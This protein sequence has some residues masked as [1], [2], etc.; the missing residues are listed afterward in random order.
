MPTEG[1]LQAPTRHP[2]GWQAP[3][4]YD[5]P[6]A[7]TELERIFHICHGCRRC[8]SLCGAFPT[9]FDLVDQGKTG[10][11][12]GVARKDY[13]KVVDQCYLC[14]L[15]YMTKCPYVPPH[16][17][18]V[19]FPHTMLRAKAIKFKQGGVGFGEKFLAATDVHGQFAGIPVVVQL[20]NAVNRARPARALME[21]T[22][23]VD[24]NAWLPAL[25]TRRFRKAAPTT[26]DFAVRAGERSPG[27][28]AIFATCYV[29][30]N[31]PG[32]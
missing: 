11:V 25:A 3:E 6:A 21:S 18:N 12:D 1:S 30:Y 23:N 20:A 31:E 4:Y 9:L 15:C 16:E 7:F 27:K 10:E 14:D 5:Q 2:I 8:V 22:L 13:W 29:N 19:D 24:R 26:Q 32:I 17:W 28:V